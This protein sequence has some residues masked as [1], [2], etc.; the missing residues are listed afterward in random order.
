MVHHDRRSVIL[1][2][3]SLGTVI[4][5]GDCNEQLNRD[6]GDRQATSCTRRPWI[7]SDDRWAVVSI[8]MTLRTEVAAAPAIL[9]WRCRQI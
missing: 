5:S 4:R 2:L 3:N 1:G 6:A 7:D 9:C 8:R